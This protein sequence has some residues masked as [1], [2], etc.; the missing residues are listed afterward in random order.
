MAGWQ[1]LVG[2]PGPQAQSNCKL[3]LSLRVQAARP[4]L[5]RARPR[6][7]SRR[8]Q[9]VMPEPNPNS[10]GRYSHWMPA[11]STNR[12]PHSRAQVTSGMKMVSTTSR[13]A[14]EDIGLRSMS[15]SCLSRS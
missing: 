7:Q 5:A 3:Q 10:L 2:S 6:A 14:D 15:T 1:K 11:F 9:Q 8:R 13:M 12:M 4:L